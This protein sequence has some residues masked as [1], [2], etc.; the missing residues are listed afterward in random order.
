MCED[1]QERFYVRRLMK[2]LKDGVIELNVEI[3]EQEVLVTL[4]SSQYQVTDTEQLIPYL[5]ESEVLLE[6][7]VKES[8]EKGM[9]IGY[10]L[11]K[12]SKTLKEATAG[13]NLERL[14]IARNLGI[15]VRWL[16]WQHKNNCF[17]LH[18]ENLFLVGKQLK[19][20]H[21]GLSKSM[22]PLEK[23]EEEV[24]KQY[25]ALVVS[26][27]QPKYSYDCLV[28]GKIQA[29]DILSKKIFEANTV[30]EVEQLLGNQY[31]GKIA[32]I[33]NRVNEWDISKVSK[34]L[35]L[36]GAIPFLVVL[37][38]YAFVIIRT[39][40]TPMG[41]WGTLLVQRRASLIPYIVVVPIYL[42]RITAHIKGSEDFSIWI[43]F[44]HGF[45]I[46]SI[47]FVFVAGNMPFLEGVILGSVVYFVVF[48]ITFIYKK[49][50]THI[51][52]KDDNFIF[53]L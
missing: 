2:T 6:G 50:I 1:D 39:T 29:Q 11:P 25:K 10:S 8:S 20:A 14:E 45:A 42:A 31:E 53:L 37:A 35:I 47:F 26:T 34:L 52:N 32:K 43:G 4:D 12:D 3:Q 18:P 49:I 15:L 48:A 9:I 38:V 22:D 24:F 13:S 27:L 46:A 41:N 23:S 17:F 5:R 33:F 28:T 21:R 7:K 19:V 16:R 51:R 36:F 40:L 44:L 30:E